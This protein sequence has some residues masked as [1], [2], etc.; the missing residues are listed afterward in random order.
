MNTLDARHHDAATLFG[1]S[2]APHE[3]R[4]WLDEPAIPRVALRLVVSTVLTAQLVLIAVLG[5]SS[6]VS[7]LELALATPVVAWAALPFHE[8][9]VLALRRRR[10][11]MFALVSLGTLTAYLYSAVAT[12]APSIHEGRTS[13]FAAAAATVTLVL[14]GERI[15]GLARRR[16]SAEI[17]DANVVRRAL[18]PTT[19]I[20]DVADRI[21][22]AIVP[23]VIVIAALTFVTWLAFGPAPKLAHA[24]EGAVAVLVIACPAAVGLASP[25][26]FLMA[27]AA[28][29]R[30]GIGLAD[31]KVSE[32]LARV[33]T[34]VVDRT[35]V[36]TEGTL[37]VHSVEAA[38]GF[39]RAELLRLAA[40]AEYECEHPVARAVVAHAAGADVA[41]GDVPISIR[42]PVAGRGV[43]ADVAGRDV[44]L[45]AHALLL[46]RGIAVPSAALAR[47]EELRRTG[48]SVS[49]VGVDSRYAGLVALGDSARE[50]AR[51][52][53]A[54]LRRMGLRVVMMTGS[55]R[56]LGRHVARELDL[57]DGEV[58]AAVHPDDRAGMIE[59]LRSRGET[60]AVVGRSDRH[61]RAASS[62][63]VGL[64]FG[65]SDRGDVTLPSGDVHAIVR[66][67]RLARRTARNV[68]QNLVLAV[69]YN[70]LAIPL[71]AV[72]GL[73]PLVAA[74][75][76]GLGTFSVLASS[77]RL[78]STDRGS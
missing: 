74:G 32:T 34:L 17:A 37:T 78:L 49:F 57:H 75:V 19:P 77:T 15:E 65:P 44:V 52:S 51:A 61:L 63:H 22:A 4:A 71:A 20:E 33:T 10:A 18:A 73:S 45:G 54:E 25:L 31:P 1:G 23:A 26:S 64:V 38:P 39:D 6:Q 16:A 42:Q 24:F 66:A 2:D 60:V 72:T 68:R 76:M 41:D 67:I 21:S 5:Q 69:A 3:G 59:K 53:I 8:R 36:L 9:A 58:F 62:A 28:A 47:A 48:A 56:T 35:G 46:A 55:S 50:S 43:I 70:L 40:A 27:T 11:N 30:A 14:L 29:K 13:F 7:W 12:I